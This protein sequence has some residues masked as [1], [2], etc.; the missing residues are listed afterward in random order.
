V[1][2]V[3]YAWWYIGWIYSSAS[4]SVPP[5]FH[6]LYILAGGWVCIEPNG[7]TLPRLLSNAHA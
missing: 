6:D 5:L 1:K 2:M 4:S 7:I 3:C